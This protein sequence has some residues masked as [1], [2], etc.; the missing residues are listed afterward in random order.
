MFGALYTCKWTIR[1]QVRICHADTS[2][3]AGIFW[4]LLRIKKGSERIKEWKKKYIFRQKTIF[5]V[6]LRIAGDEFL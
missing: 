6:L 3:G 4:G 5:Q 1:L 2:M